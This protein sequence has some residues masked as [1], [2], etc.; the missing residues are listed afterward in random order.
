MKKVLAAFFLF[1][2]LSQH[3]FGQTTDKGSKSIGVSF[4]LNDFATP[5]RIRSGS[6]DRVLREKQW[7][8][9]NEMSPGLAVSF[10]NG[11]TNHIEFAATLGASYA[12]YS[13]SNKTFST[14]ALLLEGDAS[15]NFKLLG[16]NYWVTPYATVGIG[17]SKYRSYY[18]AFVP[19]GLGLK[20]NIFN[21][22]HV[23]FNTQYRVPVTSETTAYH[24]MY[25]VGVAGAMGKK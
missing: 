7:A 5:D 19:L 14:D 20:V 1:S 15:A 21:E 25:S 3:A 16:D 22:A 12:N 9:L 18:G 6:L 8:K 4:L 2:I 23:F 17:G 24:L 11:L 13:V 10:F